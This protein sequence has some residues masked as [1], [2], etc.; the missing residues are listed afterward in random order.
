MTQHLLVTGATSGIGHAIALAY[1]I[2][3]DGNQLLR[4]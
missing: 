1:R 4:S 3:K 2:C